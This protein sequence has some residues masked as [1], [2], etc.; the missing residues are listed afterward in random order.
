MK[1]KK[2]VLRHKNG[3]SRMLILGQTVKSR[4]KARKLSYKVIFTE[5]AD[6]DEFLNACQWYESTP[7][8][9]TEM[10]FLMK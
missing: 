2:V 4:A 8:R 7:Y 9:S 5:E 1:L 6:F 10:S 3:E